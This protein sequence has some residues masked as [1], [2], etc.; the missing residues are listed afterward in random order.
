MR[1]RCRILPSLGFT[2]VE[3]LVVIA[4]IGILIA[5]LLPA[6]QAAREAARRAQCTN[7]LKQIGL[8]VHNHFDVFNILPTAGKGDWKMLPSYDEDL[9]PHPAPAQAA[10]LF[11]QILPFM[12]QKPLHDGGGGADAAEKGVI[13]VQGVVPNYFCPSRRSPAGHDRTLKHTKYYD[14]VNNTTAGVPS[15]WEK[16][17]LPIGMLDYAFVGSFHAT[18][19]CA[20]GGYSS[21]EVSKLGF[22]TNGNASKGSNPNVLIWP[23]HAYHQTKNA[24]I[25]E[26][27]FANM[28][29]G[30]S[31]CL[32]VAEKR[33]DIGDLGGLDND[34]TG[35]ASACDQ[36]IWS[37]NMMPLPDANNIGGKQFGSSHPGG[38][39]V[40]LGDGSVRFVPYTVDPLVWAGMCSI[41]DGYPFQ[42]P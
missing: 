35:Y 40:L 4:I 38:L 10:G 25:A 11:F 19:M 12:E 17:V 32:L 20:A 3:L 21:N 2:L 6:V 5:L 9:N 14:P 13:A 7:N 30:T 29:D 8:G 37:T 31:N 15:P 24:S 26:R 39:N 27:T 36:D 28:I 41:K 34:D 16:A 42:M 23:S 1:N 33:L 18:W 22:I